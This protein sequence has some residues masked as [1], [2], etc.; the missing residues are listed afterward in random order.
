[1]LPPTV[2][3]SDRRPGRPSLVEGEGSTP[4][5][6]RLSDSDYDQLC[7]EAK[8][9]RISVAELIRRRTLAAAPKDTPR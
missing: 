2:T 3:V 1:M 5:S 8:R 9:Q 4:V 6:V 7:A